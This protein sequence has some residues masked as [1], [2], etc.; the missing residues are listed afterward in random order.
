MKKWASKWLEMRSQ[1]HRFY[2]IFRG[3]GEAPAPLIKGGFI[4]LS[5]SP[6]TPSRLSLLGSRLRLPVTPGNNIS[7]SGPEAI[8]FPLNGRIRKDALSHE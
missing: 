5:Y 7:G 4:P 3:P 2:K 6:P 8:L 1:I